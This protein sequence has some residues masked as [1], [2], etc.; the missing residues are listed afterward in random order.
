[1][2]NKIQ[3]MLIRVIFIFI[4]IKTYLYNL[5]GTFACV[6]CFF[7]ILASIIYAVCDKLILLE[8]KKSTAKSSRIPHAT[9]CGETEAWC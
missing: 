1:M 3:L 9:S 8:R 7:N 2:V 6:V 4:S 5:M